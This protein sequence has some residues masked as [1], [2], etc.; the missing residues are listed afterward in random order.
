MM[1]LLPTPWSP[2][3]TMRTFSLFR[4]VFE[5]VILIL[6]ENLYHRV[7]INAVDILGEK[8][9]LIWLIGKELLLIMQSLYVRFSILLI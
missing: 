1:E 3:K 2:R 6:Y 9:F 4:L 5:E 7:G 8:E